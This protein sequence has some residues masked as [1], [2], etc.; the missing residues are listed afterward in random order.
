LLKPGDRAPDFTLPDDTGQPVSLR[1]LLA[2]G[3]VVLVFYPRDFTPVCTREVCM[4]RDVH[5]ELA[6][7]GITVLGIS[8]D[9]VASHARFRAQHALNF[10]LLADV[11]RAVCRAYGV[12]GPLGFGT[13]RVTFFIGRS[14]QIED[15]V[16]ASLRVG[17]H[18]ALLKRALTAMH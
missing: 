11:D 18:E 17:A 9:S 14:G 7:A 3:P 6:A 2:A 16:N 15:A 13:R 4:V 5:V 12:L 8:T 10:P 1:T